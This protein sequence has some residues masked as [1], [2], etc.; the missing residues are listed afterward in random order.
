M[1]IYVCLGRRF[2][3]QL[4]QLA[5]VNCGCAYFCSCIFSG[6]IVSMDQTNNEISQTFHKDR[7]HSGN[8]QWSLCPL[9]ISGLKYLFEAC[10]YKWTIYTWSVIIEYF[11]MGVAQVKK[12]NGFKVYF[13]LLWHVDNF[14]LWGFFKFIARKE[15]NS[16]NF[17]QIFSPNNCSVKIY[18]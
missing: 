4:Q 10:N 5:T 8:S 18:A 12:G 6:E 17:R 14:L 3:K 9:G 11:G 7:A 13:I 15:P 16:R 2:R 1:V